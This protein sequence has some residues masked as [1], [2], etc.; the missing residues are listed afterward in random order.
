MFFE[1]GITWITPPTPSARVACPRSRSMRSV[2]GLASHS[3]ARSFLW[4][5]GLYAAFSSLPCCS[6]QSPRL[7]RS[8]VCCGNTRDQHRNNTTSQA[9]VNVRPEMI[10][11]ETDPGPQSALPDLP[12]TQSTASEANRK[13]TPQATIPFESVDPAAMTS[14][15]WSR[16][17]VPSVARS[18]QG[19]PQSRHT[20]VSLFCT[21]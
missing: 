3:W 15:D 2:A 7:T 10:M 5:F 9:I 19:S 17:P 11:S 18:V 13:H 21:L 14:A 16:S 20:F 8:S 12:A 6:S 4:S 1:P